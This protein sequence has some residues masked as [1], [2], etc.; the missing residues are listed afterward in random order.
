MEEFEDELI[1]HKNIL[2]LFRLLSSLNI[3]KGSNYEKYEK[4]GLEWGSRQNYIYRI[5]TALD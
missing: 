4:Y 2:N 5:L 3:V 1:A